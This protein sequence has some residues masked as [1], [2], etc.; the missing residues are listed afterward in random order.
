MWHIGFAK[1]NDYSSNGHIVF[2]ARHSSDFRRAVP[3]ISTRKTLDGGVV[4]S[5][6]GFSNYDVPVN[7]I[8]DL[9][10][11]QVET[12]YS[13]I[14]TETFLRIGLPHG[15]FVGVITSFKPGNGESKIT[16]QLRN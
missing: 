4:V 11:S 15:V 7:I 12:I 2:A 16:V 3:R 1:R 9:T 5:H 10:E 14:E 8:A 6:F 13:M